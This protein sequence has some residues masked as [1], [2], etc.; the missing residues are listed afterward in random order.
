M[1]GKKLC[2]T[3]IK[4]L[5]RLLGGGIP[6]KTGVL[7]AGGPGTGK[8]IMCHEFLFRGVEKFNENGVYLDL[9]AVKEKLIENIETF[10]F[11]KKEYLDSGKIRIL[12]IQ[13]TEKLK[14]SFFTGPGSEQRCSGIV[15]QA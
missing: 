1:N 9:T 13:S 10:R 4:E 14:K 11:Y 15:L 12:D 5:D 3:G 8:T 7:V 6:I 2:E